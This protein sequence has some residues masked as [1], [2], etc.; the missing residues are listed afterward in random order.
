[1]PATKTN[2]NPN[3]ASP[4]TLMTKIKMS[5]YNIIFL[6]AYICFG[7]FLCYMKFVWNDMLNAQLT[8]N[9]FFNYIKFSQQSGLVMS[10]MNLVST[11][12]SPEITN[13]SHKVKTTT[14]PSLPY[15]IDDKKMYK[16][17]F[18]DN[19]SFIEKQLNEFSRNN[20]NV[21]YRFSGYYLA[22][23]YYMIYFFASLFY[24][25]GM[26]DI[27]TIFLGP[28]IF[29]FFFICA[30]IMS[31]FIM[32]ISI[33]KS[34]EYDW[35]IYAYPLT[36]CVILLL[37]F[38]FFPI[39]PMLHFYFLFKCIKGMFIDVQNYIDKNKVEINVSEQIKGTGI[40]PIKGT[41]ISS[42][43]SPG[44]TPPPS[45]TPE[46]IPPQSAPQPAPEPIPPPQSAPQQAPET[47]STPPETPSKPPEPISTQSPESSNQDTRPESPNTSLETDKSKTSIG[48]KTTD[49]NYKSKKYTYLN[50][51]KDMFIT[52][53][54]LQYMIFILIIMQLSSIN[55]MVG[56]IF[57]VILVLLV[58]YNLF[59]Y[60]R[61]FFKTYDE[62]KALKHDWLLNSEEPIV[63][64]EP[65]Q[66]LT[67]KVLSYMKP[68]V[69]GQI[70]ETIKKLDAPGRLIKEMGKY[71]N[72]LLN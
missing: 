48:G 41:I 62:K 8:R 46:P 61:L 66:S 57:T 15:E 51:A 28:F 3:T 30:S 22:E 9:Q 42:S 39:L 47:T 58:L 49:K 43:L 1:M 11:L 69:S 35:F 19:H 26:P 17:V 40:S 68:I 20:S 34:L 18:N 27:I 24:D 65:K 56:L 13:A 38:L 52:N 12:S 32:P 6:V 37:Y 63:L 10:V 29:I 2:T 71:N 59:K 55:N 67:S 31:I 36:F 33:F 16:H 44:P 70:N 23:L 21:I 53:G 72:I 5:I 7:I 4:P 45:T 54:W 50:Y 64:N 25:I 60:K 14:V